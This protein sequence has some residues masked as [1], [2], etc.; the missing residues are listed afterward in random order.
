MNRLLG[1]EILRRGVC[2]FFQLISIK[3]SLYLGKFIIDNHKAFCETMN[4]I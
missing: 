2:L 3:V 4:F 1:I